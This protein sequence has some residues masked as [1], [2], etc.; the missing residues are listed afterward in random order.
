MRSTSH[1]AKPKQTMM[2]RCRRSTSKKRPS[3]EMCSPTSTQ[4]TTMRF[5]MLMRQS[6]SSLLVGVMFRISLRQAG[7][8]NQHC[9]RLISTVAYLLRCLWQNN[10]GC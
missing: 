3:R 8:I 10:R 4:P 2:R 5:K 9:N 1:S 6:T 7:T